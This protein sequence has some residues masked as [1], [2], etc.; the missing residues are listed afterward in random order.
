MS[1]IT[2]ICTLMIA[3]MIFGAITIYILITAPVAIPY[4]QAKISKGMMIILQT[5]TGKRIFTATD[6]TYKSKK[7]GAF[8]PT[9]NS[10]FLI[11]GVPVA[12]G[13]VDLSVIPSPEAVQA[14][15][16]MDDV[17]APVFTTLEDS[18]VNAEKHGI[19]TKYDARALYKY[20]ANVTPNYVNS[21]IERRAAE[22]LA[23]NHNNIG[24]VFSYVIMFIMV[25]VGF[26]IAYQAFQ[27][28][29][30]EGIADALT[31]AGNAATTTVNI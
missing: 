26:A 15:Q 23:A 22:I 8:L 24:T 30:A 17:D 2:I 12:L 29:S 3:F 28:G 1:F 5:E 31:S 4:F 18:T 10:S 16:K 19:L 6:K 9:E 20:A 11:N 7:Y 13:Y 14:A 25:M 21:R 27:S